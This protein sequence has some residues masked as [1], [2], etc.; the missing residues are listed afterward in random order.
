LKS[1]TLR[2]R[3]K[4]YDENLQRQR[5]DLRCLN[6]QVTEGFIEF[7]VGKVREFLSQRKREKRLRIISFMKWLNSA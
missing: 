3:D 2:L 4:G 5:E 7:I 1:R 6:F